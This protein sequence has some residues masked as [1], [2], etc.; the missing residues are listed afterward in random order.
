MPADP[1]NPMLLPGGGDFC[2]WGSAGSNMT[3]TSITATDKDRNPLSNQPD[4]ALLTGLLGLDWGFAVS[5]YSN[6]SNFYLVYNY[7]VDGS[8]G[9][10][11]PYGP[12]YTMGGG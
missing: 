4:W 8:S 6:Q 2:C 1:M 9:Q 11:A 12:Y 7:T 10:S 5:N 3:V